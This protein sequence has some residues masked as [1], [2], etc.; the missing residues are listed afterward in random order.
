MAGLPGAEREMAHSPHRRWRGCRVCDTHKIRGA[1]RAHKDPFPLIRK[2]GKRRRLTRHDL[3][4]AG[5]DR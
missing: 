5:D 2:L 3:G 4:D 1:G